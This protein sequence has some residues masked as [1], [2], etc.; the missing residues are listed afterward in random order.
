MVDMGRW[1]FAEACRQLAAWRREYPELPARRPGQHVAGAVRDQRPGRVRGELPA[2]APHTRRAP[3]HRNDRARRAAGARA[4]GAHPAGVPGPR[5]RGGHRRLR[6]GLRLVHRAQAPAGQL[7]QARPDLRAGH[8]R[9]TPATGPSSRRSS[10]SGRA[11]DLGVIAEGIEYSAT[12]DK[13][14]ELGCHRGQGY[15]M[16]VPMSPEELAPV[17]R[18]GAVPLVGVPYEWKGGPR[19]VGQVP[20]TLVDDVDARDIDIDADGDGQ[21]H[22]P[23]VFLTMLDQMS[24]SEVNIGFIYSVLDLL[25]RRYRLTD[26]VVVLRDEALGTQAFRLGQKSLDGD[27]PASVGHV[28]RASSASPTCVPHVVRDVVRNVCQLALTL[29]LAR[30]SADHDPLTNIA[31]RRHFDAALRNAVGPERRGTAGPSR[32]CWST[33]TGSRPSTTGSGTPWATTCCAPSAGRCAAPCAAATPRPGWA[34]TSSPSFSPTPRGPRSW[35]SPSGSGPSWSPC[36][37]ST[38]R[39]APP[40]RPATRPT[41]PSSTASPTRRLYEKKGIVLAMTSTIEEDFELELRSLPGV[42]NVGINHRENG[43]VESVVL[44]IRNHDPEVG[45]GERRRRWPA[46]TTPTP[47]SSWRRPTGAPLGARRRARPGSRS[48]AAEFNEHDGVSEVHLELRRSHRGRAGR[49]A[50]RSSAGPRP[51]WPPCATSATSSPST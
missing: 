31:N 42:V 44:S 30:H 10:S 48:C 20:V 51:R 23:W 9:P 47:R 50:G 34:A 38:S 12:I 29:H 35:P 33:S 17:L 19:T 32:W 45:P 18:A 15:L 14:L 49:A 2:G 4:D 36:P 11:L 7:P 1:V 6:D 21:L 40:R 27:S 26:A 13:L 16:S 25:A 39:S 43:E 24:T 46:S 28:A 3:L 5:R 22:E 37:S 41:P 8:R